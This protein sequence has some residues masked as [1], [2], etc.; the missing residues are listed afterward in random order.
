MVHLTIKFIKH[1]IFYDFLPIIPDNLM[2]IK[3]SCPQPQPQEQKE[4]KFKIYTTL[5]FSCNGQQHW[6]RQ[7]F[8]FI[9][10]TQ[11]T[12]LNFT[13]CMY[14]FD[15]ICFWQKKSLQWEI[16]IQDKWNWINWKHKRLVCKFWTWPLIALEAVAKAMIPWS[17]WNF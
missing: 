8:S 4:V 13:I 1:Q 5:P 15:K 12:F 14:Q 9:D 6:E 10:S 17:P 7:C 11:I 3:Q 16:M 2:K